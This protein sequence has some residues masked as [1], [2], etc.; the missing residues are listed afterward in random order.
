VRRTNLGTLRF[1]RESRHDRLLRL[2]NVVGTGLGVKRRGGDV[3]N[4]AALVVFVDRKLP[5]TDL[6][7]SSHVPAYVEH[8]GQRIPTDVVEIGELRLEFGAAPYFISDLAT[9]GVV[10]AFARTEGM[11]HIVSCAH[12]LR[13]EDGDPHTISPIGVWDAAQNK[14]VEVGQTMF[15][16]EAPGF[17]LPGNFGFV[18]AGFAGLVHR[19]MI[20]QARSAPPLPIGPPP[21]R[22]LAVVGRGAGAPIEG[23]I[24]AVEAV[25]LGRRTDMLIRMTGAGSFPGHSG[26]LWRTKS[27]LGV[28]VHTYGAQFVTGG[29]SRYSLATGIRRV[30]R[31][32][33]VDL[34]D[35]G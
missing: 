4:T 34:F 13:G 9:K 18:D 23:A 2:P 16:V 35:P 26:M 12:C 7:T 29:G 22:G 5:L 28:G 21:R 17:G 15:A 32:L 19:E 24:D 20:D 3:I 33:Q 1:A 31:Q 10:T 11:F 27:G 14:Y 25:I 8:G 6:R 30:A